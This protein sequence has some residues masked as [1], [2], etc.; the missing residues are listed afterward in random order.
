VRTASTRQQA[1]DTLRNLETSGVVLLC[2]QR[3]A[4]GDPPGTELIRRWRT[5][6]PHIER[7]VLATAS[8]D[9]PAWPIGVDAVLDKTAGPEAL[10][11]AV[12]NAIVR[13]KPSVGSIGG[14]L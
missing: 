3:L 8:L 7:A 9:V 14:R 10:L 6:Y 5:E 1:E 12:D 13:H 11:E 2:G 4:E